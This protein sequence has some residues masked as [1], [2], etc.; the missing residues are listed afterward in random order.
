LVNYL[1]HKIT[2]STIIHENTADYNPKNSKGEVFR[3]EMEM[4]LVDILGEIGYPVKSS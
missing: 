2:N 1:L 3:K 4:E